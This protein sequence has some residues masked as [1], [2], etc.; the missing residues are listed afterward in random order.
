MRTAF[1]QLQNAR[2]YSYIPQV[3][4]VMYVSHD[5]RNDGKIEAARVAETYDNYARPEN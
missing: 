4:S 5:R 3:R 2:F 1:V